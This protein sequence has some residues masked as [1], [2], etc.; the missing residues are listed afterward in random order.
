MRR[1]AGSSIIAEINITP[2][3]DVFLVLLIIVIIVAPFM[4]SM[5]KGVRPP[6]VLGGTT[7][8]RQAL[9]LEIDREGVYFIDGRQVSPDDLTD[10]LSARI[11]SQTGKTLVIRGDRDSQSAA[12]LAAMDA[13][14]VAGAEQ[15]ILAGI[16]QAEPRLPLPTQ[17]GQDRAER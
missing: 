13:A 5:R 4:A 11:A 14:R 16:S 1:T 8:D 9:T 10:T 15:V 7:L 17:S 2:L 6:Q 3:T 12:A